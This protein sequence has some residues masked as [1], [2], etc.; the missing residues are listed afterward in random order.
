MN[1]ATNEVMEFITE[2][3]ELVHNPDYYSA[4]WVLRRHKYGCKPS[5]FWTT[6]AVESLC[7]WKVLSVKGDNNYT[8]RVRFF[9]EKDD[10]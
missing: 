8:R 3:P 10:A 5:P 6:P 9:M 2:R 4:E 7:E 1:Y